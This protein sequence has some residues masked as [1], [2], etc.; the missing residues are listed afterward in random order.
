[1]VSTT[2]WV[3]GYADSEYEYFVVKRLIPQIQISGNL[4]EGQR[5]ECG[6]EVSATRV[7]RASEAL[8]YY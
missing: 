2:I 5:S 3:I 6:H 8:V 7:A 4:N 1:M